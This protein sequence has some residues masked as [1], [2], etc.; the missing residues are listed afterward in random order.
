MKNKALLLGLESFNE[1]PAVMADHTETV[2]SEYEAVETL[3][4]REI[5]QCIDGITSAETDIA[6]LEALIEAIEDARDVGMEAWSAQFATIHVNSMQKRYSVNDPLLAMPSLECFDGRQ[7][8]LATTVSLESV[9]E[10]AAKVWAWIKE[11]VGKFVDMMRD[12]YR[13]VTKNLDYIAEQARVLKNQARKMKFEGGETVDLGRHG[14]KITVQGKISNDF[15]SVLN[16]VGSFTRI[17][18]ETFT[19]IRDMVSKTLSET[20]EADRFMPANIPDSVPIPSS[21]TKVR[22]ANR[23]A[24]G[25]GALNVY[26][27]PILPGDRFIVIGVFGS[28][29]TSKTYDFRTGGM[30]YGRV[31]Q[32]N[33]DVDRDT[34]ATTLSS[35]EVFTLCQRLDKTVSSLKTSQDNLTRHLEDTR[36]E[37]DNIMRKYQKGDGKVAQAARAV[38]SWYYRNTALYGGNLHRFCDGIAF[39]ICMGYLTLAKKSMP[40]EKAEAA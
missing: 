3:D 4:G 16:N 22:E 19:Q 13:R 2:G 40:V 18:E 33:A 10:T 14:R 17:G 24:I 28:D 15:V 37:I 26:C 23:F 25:A 5:D 12:F 35:T 20:K 31:S 8:R 7:A 21:F 36:K 38:G 34:T 1:G 39:D 29:N 27:S 6:S 11:M 9:G 32:Q 30:V